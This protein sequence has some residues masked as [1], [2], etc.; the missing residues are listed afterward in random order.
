MELNNVAGLENSLADVPP[1][2]WRS[3]AAVRRDA[4][5]PKELPRTLFPEIERLL[6]RVLEH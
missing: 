5:G 6:D 2:S 1:R 4:D 3:T